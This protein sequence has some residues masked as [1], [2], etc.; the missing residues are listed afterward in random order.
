MADD[1]FERLREEGFI[2]TGD[3]P[4]DGLGQ[5][6]KVGLNR[7]GNEL[8]NS[9][10]VEAARRVFQTTGYSDGL[11]RVGDF[12]FKQG[13]A[14]DALKM[15]WLAKDRRRA[16]ELIEKIARIIQNLLTEEAKNGGRR[17]ERAPG[18]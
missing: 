17:E 3:V 1:P 11:I 8:F 12:Y 2:K 16:G 14:V 6:E 4:R 7:R 13:R 9:G 15:Y 18:G 5:A 10:D